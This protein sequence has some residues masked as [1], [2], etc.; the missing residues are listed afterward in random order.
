[1]STS[2]E[3]AN[4]GATEATQKVLSE[5]YPKGLDT[6]DIAKRLKARGLYT[7]SKHFVAT[8]YATLHNASTDGD[9]PSALKTP[10]FVRKNGLWYLARA[11]VGR[12][13]GLE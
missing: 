3:F 10:K 12:A 6:T 2:M 7:R 11:R 8:V 13:S 1:M 4:M 9:G 5:G